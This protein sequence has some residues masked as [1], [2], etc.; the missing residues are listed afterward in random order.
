MDRTISAAS[1]A[2][3]ED[4]I[5]ALMSAKAILLD[6]DG[7]A[8]IANHPLP[9]TIDF[10][11]LYGDRVVIVSNNSTL[12][13]SDIAEALTKAGARFPTD[14]ILLAGCEA[15]IAAAESGSDVR[16]LVLGSSRM[17]AFAKKLG[18]NLV[19]ENIELVVLLRDTRFSYAK[20]DRAVQ[21]LRLGARL[22]VANPD[23][24]HPGADG[25]LVPETGAL[26][27]AMGA[28]VDLAAIEMAVIGKPSAR[29]FEKACRSLQA[30]PGQAVMIGDNPLT[31]IAGAQA[32]GMESILV[33]PGS[34]LTLRD[35]T[36]DGASDM[37]FERL[38]RPVGVRSA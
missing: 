6:W 24:T 37:A 23:K 21:A 11:K 15:L 9:M 32:V 30:S 19:Q 10:L 29:L 17:K 1:L 14:R 20:L 4:R 33:A 27:A 16:A 25:A 35:L 18:L 28:C 5:A 2:R 8:S 26:L 3:V 13:P 38:T 7:C 31:D 34:A 12:L 22:I 36:P